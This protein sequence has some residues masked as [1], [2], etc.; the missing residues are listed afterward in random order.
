[1]NFDSTVRT[2]V[3][4]LAVSSACASGCAD[5]RRGP[6]WDQTDTDATED[7]DGATGS[8]APTFAL[9]VYPL[10]EVGCEHCHAPEESA[11]GTGFLV[12]P[13]ID[14]TFDI[15]LDF[16]DPND[17]PASQLLMKTA[18]QAHGGG[19]IYES[20]S[21]EFDTILRWIEEGTPP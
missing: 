19:I 14:A 2:L 12:L 8:G 1:M 10:F 16:V 11:G 21:D 5:F 3:A 17:P 18:G 4:V 6:Y 13:D 15:T 20:K 7:T 9:D